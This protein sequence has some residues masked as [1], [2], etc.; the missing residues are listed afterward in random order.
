MQGNTYQYF[1]VSVDEAGNVSTN[2]NNGAFYTFVAQPAATILLVDAYTYTEG[3]ERDDIAIPVTSYTD[4]LNQTGITYEVWNV[5]SEGS[6]T[7]ADLQP[8]RV[9]LSDKRI[10]SRR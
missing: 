2:N 6:P 4:A 3:T 10:V 9:V 7:T 1:V 5:Q 8:F